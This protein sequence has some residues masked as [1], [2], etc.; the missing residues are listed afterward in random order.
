MLRKDTIR[1]KVLH[2]AAFYAIV[3]Q[4]FFPFGSLFAAPESA[5]A[6]FSDTD[7]PILYAPVINHTTESIS[8]GP[9]EAKEVQD[10]DNA[11]EKN[12][13]LAMPYGGPGQSE[14]SGFSL[15]S[16]DGSVDQFTGDFS[17]SIPVMDVEGY[18]IVLSYNSNVGMLDEASW[19]GLGWNLNVGSVAR[20]MRGIPDEF[21]GSD[22]ITRVYHV[23]E[24][25]I[26]NGWKAGITGGV[27][28]KGLILSRQ[29]KLGGD[30]SLLF[31]KYKSSYIGN[32]RTFDFN[33][34][35]TLATTGS[36]T[37]DDAYFGLK[38]GLGVSSD[39][40]NGI[41]RSSSIGG[42]A[43][44]GESDG[45]SVNGSF[46]LSY[47]Q[48]YHSRMGLTQ[49]FIGSDFA[50]GAGGTYK[51]KKE[52]I[53]G[54]FSLPMS[55]GSTYTCGSIT[56]VPQYEIRS[57]STSINNVGDLTFS[58]SNKP[59]V[60]KPK[61]MFTVGV[62]KQDYSSDQDFIYSTS[63]NTIIN[64]AFGYFHLKKRETY[65][66]WDRP[67]MDYNRERDVEFSEEM[68]NLPFSFPTYDVFY[69]NGMGMSATFRGQR[70]DVGNYN[71]GNTLTTSDGNSDNVSVGL[72]STPASTTTMSINIG[73]VHGDDIGDARSGKWAQ[74]GYNSSVGPD[75]K[76][77]F[78]AIGEPTPKNNA[79]LNQVGGE[80]P[81][82][83]QLTDDESNL[84][85]N[86]TN[87]LYYEGGSTT[88]NSTNIQNAN[89]P[90]TRANSYRPVLASELQSDNI[91]DRYY[92]NDFDALNNTD[93][94]HVDNAVVAKHKSNHI[95]GVEVQAVNGMRY[96]YGL[97]VYSAFQSTV[98]YSTA[99]TDGNSQNLITVLPGE[100]TV[101]NTVPD[102]MQL[103]DKT[104]V[105]SHPTAFLLT[106][107]NSADYVDL[108]DPGYTID[109]IGDYYKIN[110]TRVY[111]N[112]NSDGYNWRMPMSNEAFFN[113]GLLAT[114][115]DNTASY[116][117]GTK[118]IWYTHS[119][120]SKN[121]IAEFTLAP[122][123]DAYSMSEAGTIITPAAPLY[124]IEKITLYNREDRIENGT[125]AKKLQEVEFIY[126][127]SLCPGNPLTSGAPGGQTGKLTLKEVRVYSG[128]KSQETALQP[129]V[130][131]YSSNNPSF[132]YQSTDRWGNY[133]PDSDASRPQEYFPQSEQ[134]VTTANTNASAWKLTK[135]NMPSGS[136]MEL[137]YEADSYRYV[138]NKRAM[139]LK[140]IK[141]YMNIIEL[142]NV[143]RTTPGSW[144]GTDHISNNLH[145]AMSSST[146]STLT[147]MSIGDLQQMQNSVIGGLSAYTG[148][149][150]ALLA[151]MA[152]FDQIANNVLIVELDT[153]LSGIS[154]ADA[155]IA[156]REKYLK[157]D[158]SATVGSGYLK[159]L[160]LKNFVQVK[161]A[162]TTELIQT[163]AKIHQGTLLLS[164]LNSN[165][166]AS[167]GV[168]P[169]NG[170][171]Q[172][173]YG[174]IVLENVISS[175]DDK[176][177]IA[178]HPVQK[179]ALEFSKLHLTDIVYGS[180]PDC[181]GDLTI[182]RKAFWRGDIY[183]EMAKA[184]YCEVITSEMP[185]Q[186]RLFDADNKKMGGNARVKKITMRDN[187]EV[188][189]TQG[190][191]AEPGT[192]YTWTYDYDRESYGVAA[193]EPMTGNDENPFFHWDRYTNKSVS[194]PDASKYTI[195]PIGESLFP[196]PVVGYKTVALKLG[197]NRVFTANDLGE[198]RATFCTA[199]EYPTRAT[200]GYLQ[201]VDAKKNSIFK[202]EV[203]LFGFSQGHSVVTNDFHGKPLDYRVYNATGVLQ[204][205]TT[206]TYK[207]PGE[208]VRMID[209]SGHLSDETVAA[210]YDIY[211]DARFTT[212]E[213]A[214]SLLGLNL[215]WPLAPTPSP[216][217][218]GITPI[219][220]SSY[221]KVGFYTHVFNKHINYSAVVE[222]IETESL[223]SVNTAQDLLYDK[224]TGAVLL[225]SLTDEYN[226]PLY[227][228]SYPAHWY[229]T[230][231]RNPL[232]QPTAAVSGTIAI[233]K[234]TASS[235]LKDKFT[236]GDEVTVTNGSTVT[237][238]ALVVTVD[239]TEIQLILKGGGYSASDFQTAVPAGSYTVQLTKSGRKNLTGIMMQ[240]VVTKRKP[241]LAASTFSF[242]TQDILEASAVTF[243]PKTN[244][245]CRIEDEQKPGI[246][247]P[248]NHAIDPFSRGLLNNL[249]A[250]HSYVPQL[251]RSSVQTQGVRY[252]GTY[253][254]YYPFF[255]Q[256]GSGEW[257]KINETG[258]PN[259]DAT[260]LQKWR[261][262][263]KI[264]NLD[265][266]GR[267]LESRDQIN[268][269]SAIL[270]GYNRNNK[271]VPVAQAVNAQQH[272]IAYDSFDD[273]TY[274]STLSGQSGHFDFAAV[275]TTSGSIKLSSSQHH[276]GLS[277]L[278]V[279]GGVSA[280][281][282]RPVTRSVECMEP[283]YA[284][285]GRYYLVDSCMCVK[286]F[287]PVQG[288]EYLISVWVKG[289]SVNTSGNYTDAVAEVSF[290]GGG[291][292]V[293]F[294]PTGQTLDG[295]Q[296]VEG[297]FTVPS[298]ASTITVSLKNTS[299]GGTAY[300]DDI[301]I[302]PVLAGMTT[303]VYD[304]ANLLPMAT[305]DGYNFTTFYG[306]DEN[307]MPVRVR[308]ETINGI[309]TVS[310]SEGSSIKDPKN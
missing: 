68:K 223:G 136:E 53:S 288:R 260:D 216:I 113:E 14:S 199:Y 212:S 36:E 230:L 271:F 264:T 262:M 87:N 2:V 83:I 121:L 38:G 266:F 13:A 252:N 182:D 25:D 179:T 154:K 158:E 107:I 283:P 42:T 6:F 140:D 203:R 204:A 27:L 280:S 79:L 1:F 44:F 103:Y 128:D 47:G 8:A 71:D 86:Q 228:F 41:G 58:W 129:Y 208:K 286:A 297:T 239:G 272:E 310:E 106:G 43:S 119:V 100:A 263:G 213:I 218:N 157:E 240:S 172:F 5:P 15:N 256:N 188:I 69:V 9:S 130:F 89:V 90:D 236:V 145:D 287:E 295:W 151:V 139:T 20:E 186:V 184:G 138:Q 177:P 258:H 289:N 251:E 34:G 175:E 195:T 261:P 52:N 224:E 192:E 246:S 231:F 163:F 198:S 131:T 155:D 31:G 215:S 29:A 219:I 170:S 134:N 270:Y 3:M 135:I 296:R 147:G 73:Y 201:K 265:E 222:K 76:L 23:K 226:E 268:V 75:D 156:F 173:E 116:S 91:I 285:S 144:N 233:N 193:Y 94:T 220:S 66:G 282:S 176:R 26:S 225:S 60:G 292:P 110:H 166:V 54:S 211:T 303:T 21:D 241:N 80:K 152:E 150:P 88:W 18:P 274:Y 33:V 174:Y 276:S 279:D 115:R 22:A 200:T 189:S 180:C 125:N 35:A 124:C 59:G 291:S 300:F 12:V 305:H 217:P 99:S 65:S 169:A 255:A 187:W 161:G 235:S 190:P 78:K 301:R 62:E 61:W 143:F 56:S 196:S 97:P 191:N 237:K 98:T 257:K 109:D 149:T 30:I 50:F 112:S 284:M 77:Y 132:S 123:K 126:D 306:Y 183:R 227:S 19:V 57:K 178:M 11:I 302:H 102:R 293:S 74:S 49:R 278:S 64:P 162:E 209:R 95:A 242:P 229:Y 244:V 164:L 84:K 85:I 108:G 159:E 232:E 7:M 304:P 141:G 146:I 153:P 281:V 207:K 253:A 101:T 133:K 28:R 105:P 171:G 181:D 269:Y 290:T 194:F 92:L 142:A 82:H 267:P 40:K 39:K 238:Q 137:E 294:S 259:M 114:D 10:S 185:S 214:T 275:V 308:V 168:M 277:S 221:R 4:S 248:V 51:W 96:L 299:D 16:M 48:N 93:F 247:V 250:E 127:Y 32:S 118:E 309:Q 70:N 148:G 81:A 243:R 245:L 67:V 46:G 273:Y 122:R 117:F 307:L 234:F 24:D 249:V 298:N 206:Y 167:T 160:Y 45:A 63:N 111:G 205:R 55:F 202:E 210:E 165:N 120:E 197:G 37:K 17:Y 254:G 72:S 104:T